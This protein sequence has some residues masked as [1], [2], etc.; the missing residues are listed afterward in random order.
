MI[1]LSRYLKTPCHKYNDIRSFQI[2]CHYEEQSDEVISSENQGDCFVVP[3]DSRRT[4]C[5]G[6]VITC[7]LRNQVLP[8]TQNSTIFFLKRDE[9]LNYKMILQSMMINCK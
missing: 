8:Q 5:N 4:P 7:S 9:E 6:T 1:N 2:L 3:R